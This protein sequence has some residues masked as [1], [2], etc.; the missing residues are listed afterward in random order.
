[1]PI[2]SDYGD[3]VSERAIRTEELKAIIS[4]LESKAAEEKCKII[5]YIADIPESIDR[6]IVIC[7]CYSLMKW[8]EVADEIGGYNTE[9]N[10]RMRFNRLFKN[11]KIEQ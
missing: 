7:R 2:S 5:R 8:K 6:Q 11:E 1:M 4:K 10:V 3:K 9:D